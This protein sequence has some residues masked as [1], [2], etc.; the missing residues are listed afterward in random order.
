MIDDTEDQLEVSFPASPVFTRI[1]RVAVAGL[2]LRLG[3]EIAVVERLRL[4][5]DTAVD[6]LLGAGRINMLAQWQPDL[7]SISLSNPEVH[8]DGHGELADQLSQLVGRATVEDSA[9]VLELQ[10]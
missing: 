5:V 4:A 9:I 6:A 8:V 10:H 2:A 1:G 3:V 7:L